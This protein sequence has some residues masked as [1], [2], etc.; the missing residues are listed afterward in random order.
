MWWLMP[1]LAKT[2]GKKGGASSTAIGAANLMG[3]GTE[4]TPEGKPNTD[5]ATRIAQNQLWG[6]TQIADTKTD[7]YSPFFGA[8]KET[9]MPNPGVGFNLPGQQTPFNQSD[10]FAELLKKYLSTKWR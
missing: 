6:Q 3:L 4:E 2:L 5:L 7:P 8:N 10:L 1:L 9:L